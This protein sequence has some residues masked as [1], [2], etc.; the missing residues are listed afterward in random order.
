MA[1]I[2]N[3]TSVGFVGGSFKKGGYRFNLVCGLLFVVLISERYSSIFKSLV[4]LFLCVSVFQVFDS[5]KGEFC[6]M[7]L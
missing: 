6:F 1:F 3:C 7:G 2:V 5:Q 4:P